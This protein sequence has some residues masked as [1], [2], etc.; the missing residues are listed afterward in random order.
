[1]K[2]KKIKIYNILI[3]LTIVSILTYLTLTPRF[4][5][6]VAIVGVF[7]FGILHGSNDISVIEK[8][9]GHTKQNNFWKTLAVYVS[10]IICFVCI[11]YFIP[12]L[13]L[14][15]FVVISAY[16][17]GEQHFHHKIKHKSSN[18]VAI[19][20]FAYGIFVLF[21]LFALNTNEVKNILDDMT[22]ILFHK[23]LFVI[24]FVS[25]AITTVFLFCKISTLNVHLK[26]FIYNEVLFLILFSV[27][28]YIGDVIWSFATYFVLWHSLP[29]LKD[30]VNA[31]YGPFNLNNFIKYFKQAF[32]YWIISIIGMLVVVLF[33][34]DSKSFLSLLFAFIA[35]ITFPH[36]YVM[37]KL[38]KEN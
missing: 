8:F 38:F 25:S 28:F 27:L 11:F 33:F 31:L 5:Q 20:Y 18:L 24:V 14:L 34:K 35:A 29:S 22:G 1:M 19:F 16:H 17:F 32:P 4:V 7:S 9:G 6:F 21:M 13:A 12:L 2:H 30:Q 15:F 10:V 23:T 3:L 37:R 36:V 26:S